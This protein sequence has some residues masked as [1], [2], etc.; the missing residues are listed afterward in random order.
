[1]TQALHTMQ[2]ASSSLLVYSHGHIA[3]QMQGQVVVPCHDCRVV[4]DA[5]GH[6]RVEIHVQLPGERKAG[7]AQNNGNKQHT[8]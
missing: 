8:G 4:Y 5:G 7:I 6:Q 3:V 1:M 2:I